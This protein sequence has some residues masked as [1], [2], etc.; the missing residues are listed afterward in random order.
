MDDTNFDRESGA[1]GKHREA[2]LHIDRQVE[3]LLRIAKKCE[4]KFLGYILGM[5]KEETRLLLQDTNG[6]E[7]MG[8][9]YKSD[10]S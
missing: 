5:A 6:G 4:A 2:L 1:E 9:D 10:N 3:G 8:E 7:S